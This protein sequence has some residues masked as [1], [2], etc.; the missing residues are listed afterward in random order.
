[1]YNYDVKFEDKI[2]SKLIHA[3]VVGEYMIKL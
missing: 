3:P 1:M 2:I